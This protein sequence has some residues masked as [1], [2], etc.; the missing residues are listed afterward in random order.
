MALM[1][2]LLPTVDAVLFDLDGTLV[3]TNIDFPAM[4]R[5]MIELAVEQG[6]QPSDLERL[7][8][9]AIVQSACRFLI[10]NGRQVEAE[11]LHARAM[12]ILEEI[13][14][15]HASGT[16]EIPFARSLTSELAGRGIPFGVVTRNCRK[17]SEISL[18][19]VGIAPDVLISRDDGLRHKPHPAPLH[20]ALNALGA[21]PEASIMVGD[22]LMDIQSGKAAGMKTIGFL[23]EYRAPDFFDVTQPDL[24]VRSL[25]EV[26]HAIVGPD[27]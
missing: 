22:H 23:R 5:K 26:F 13:E 15:A 24:V 10:L 21:R 4:K 18:A 12:S 8:I 9:L 20:S 19:I 25:Q 27:R 3:E 17:A 2:P 14:L 11:A 6:M 1:N 7:D 16:Q